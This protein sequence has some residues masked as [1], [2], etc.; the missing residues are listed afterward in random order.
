MERH[1]VLSGLQRLGLGLEHVG[2]HLSTVGAAALPLD[3][4]RR[5]IADYWATFADDDASVDHGWFGWETSFYSRHVQRG[6]RLLV[7]GCGTCRDVIPFLRQGHEVTGI[8]ISRHALARGRDALA[9]RDLAA[10]LEVCDLPALPLEPVYDLVVFSY[11]CYSYIPTGAARRAQLAAARA[12]LAPKG[13]VLISHF[14]V[15]AQPRPR[16]RLAKVASRL[17]GSDWQPEAGDRFLRR[18]NGVLFEHMYA[19][20]ELRAEAELMGLEVFEAETLDGI[21]LSALRRRRASA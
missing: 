1:V 6:D 18:D 8:D 5:Q 4:F 10:R 13:R 20:G 15:A 7:V 2:R 14:D 3:D 12:R 17:S 19:R 11:G 21:R 9:A 16:N